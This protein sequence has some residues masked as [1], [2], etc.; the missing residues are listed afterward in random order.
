MITALQVLPWLLWGLVIWVVG[1]FVLDVWLRWR[2]HQA[3]MREW[4][5]IQ[6]LADSGDPE[7]LREAA[8]LYID[9][10]QRGPYG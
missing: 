8:R 4:A 9:K 5:H 1:R 6:E 3:S 10:C 2:R 7:K